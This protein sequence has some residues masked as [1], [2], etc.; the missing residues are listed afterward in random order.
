MTPVVDRADVERF[1]VAVAKRLGLNYDNG[2]LHFL[3][4]VLRQRMEAAGCHRFDSYVER[5]HTK[6]GDEMGA[7]AEHLTVGE[8]FFFRNPDQLRAFA[9]IVLPGR[10][11]ARARTRQVRVLSAGCASGEEPYSLAIL[12]REAIPDLTSWDVQIVGVDVNP[13][14]LAKGARAQYS[15]WALRATSEESKRRYFRRDGKS[16][17]LDPTIQR[18]VT[19]EE[20][21]LVDEDLAFWQPQRFDVVFCCN[22]IMYFTPEIMREVVNRIGQALA[23]D[24]FLFLGHAE[25][26]RGLSQDF[27][28]RH[29]HDTFYYQRRQPSDGL[30]ASTEWT[31]P[32]PPATALPAMVEM[33]ASWVDVIQKASERIA[34]LADRRTRPYD[35]EPEVSAKAPLARSWDLSVVLEAMRQERYS[36]ALKLLGALPPDADDE[37]DA[38]LLRA[39]LL[40]NNGELGEAEKACARLLALEELNSGAHYVMALCREHAGDIKGAVEHDRTAVYL[41]SAFA[42]PHMHRGL[43]ARRAGDVPTAQRELNQALMLLARED[44]ARVLLFGGGFSRETLLQLCRTE[45]RTVGGEG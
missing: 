5:L 24:G 18:M 34:S 45:L 37:P 3:G 40:T 42:M 33:T 20:R 31:A 43:M 8:T 41:D 36:D 2:K 6:R 26:L 29:T 19:L 15:A 30:T 27:H 39:V 32:G 17:V 22:V 1:R 25:T 7:L 38:L 13:S 4:D 44:A 35:D 16:Y 11:R 12:L 23:P 21:N 10:L 14:M 28:L 9:E